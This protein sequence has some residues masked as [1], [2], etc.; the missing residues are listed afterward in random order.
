M[1]S[2]RNLRINSLASVQEQRQTGP[3]STGS[4]DIQQSADVPLNDK[5]IASHTSKN[6][7]NLKV[8]LIVKCV[9]IKKITL[10]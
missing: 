7:G 6:N 8:D 2:E 1:Q 4:E 5:V 9:R 3:E 10:N